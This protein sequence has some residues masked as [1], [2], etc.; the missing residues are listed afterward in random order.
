MHLR[1]GIGLLQLSNKP[2]MVTEHDCP[3]M[4]VTNNYH[5]GKYSVKIVIVFCN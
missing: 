4:R 1:L 5:L 2:D 3:K